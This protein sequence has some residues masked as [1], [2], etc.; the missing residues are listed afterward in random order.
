MF[1]GDSISPPFSQCNALRRFIPPVNGVGFRANVSVSPAT[2]RHPSVTGEAP[3]L[4]PGQFTASV[5]GKPCRAFQ[6]RSP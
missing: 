1:G 3:A 5:Y 6:R 4:E 2:G